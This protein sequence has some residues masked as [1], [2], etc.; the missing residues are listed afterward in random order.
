MTRWQLVSFVHR[1][2]SIDV[3]LLWWFFVIY[4]LLC[5]FSSSVVFCVIY[6]RLRV[7]FIFLIYFDAVLIFTYFLS[8]NV[9]GHL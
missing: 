6:L 2:S 1:P 5:L 4:L 7:S 3:R 8:I 9:S